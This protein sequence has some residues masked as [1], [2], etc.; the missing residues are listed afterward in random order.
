MIAVVII[1]VG[2]SERESVLSE[3][4]LE[5]AKPKEEKEKFI[6]DGTSTCC[7]PPIDCTE[8]DFRARETGDYLLPIGQRYGVFL[9]GCAMYVY[10]ADCRGGGEDHPLGVLQDVI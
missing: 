2:E 1:S 7:R 10:S 9:D 4:A 6:V 5:T 3:Q 8:E